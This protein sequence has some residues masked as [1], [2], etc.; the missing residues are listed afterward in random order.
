MMVAAAKRDK[1]WGDYGSAMKAL[2]NA[3][4]RAFVEFY[5]W[6]IFTNAKQG[7]LR[8]AGQLRG[9]M[10]EEGLLELKRSLDA[11]DARD[12]RRRSKAPG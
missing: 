7:F 12:L 8:R 11:R 1:E 5:L 6:E 2:P 9:T 10:S 4:W 3:R